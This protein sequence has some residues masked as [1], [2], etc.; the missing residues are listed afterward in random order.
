MVAVANRVVNPWLR[1]QRF[2]H[3]SIDAYLS[4]RLDLFEDLDDEL[5][6]MFDHGAVLA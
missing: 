5:V 6:D 1:R 3:P 4:G 2:P